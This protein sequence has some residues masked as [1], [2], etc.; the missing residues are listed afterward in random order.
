[1]VHI[2]MELW[3][4]IVAAVGAVLA[5]VLGGARIQRG[6]NKSTGK[7]H[8]MARCKDHGEMCTKIEVM[9]EKV[10]KIEKSSE[11]TLRELRE[12]A[13]EMREYI[14]QAFTVLRQHEGR[15]GKI[16]GVQDGMRE[17]K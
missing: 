14:D 8:Q 4:E 11:D 16:E 15:I 5:G 17:Q 2:N 1:M 9:A 12:F 7:Q 10:E 6:K 3:Q 13:K